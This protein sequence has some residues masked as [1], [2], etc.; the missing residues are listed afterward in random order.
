MREQRRDPAADLSGVLVGYATLDG[1]SPDGKTI[2]TGVTAVLPRGYHPQPQP[3]WAGFHRV[4]GNGEM[5]GTTWLQESG[6]LEGPIGITNTPSVGVVRDASL[7]WQ[8]TRPGLQPWGLPVVAETYDG[9]LNDRVQT[10][11]SLLQASGYRTSIAGKWHLG[12]EPHNLP[13]ARGFDF[14]VIQ[15]DSGSDNFEMRAY[16]PMTPE[17]Y[18]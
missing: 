18:W 15:A 14:S 17:A 10:I 4:N 5:T 16:M 11:A 3:V 8:A 1:Q 13:P 2:K 6:C 7:E 9:V 12:E